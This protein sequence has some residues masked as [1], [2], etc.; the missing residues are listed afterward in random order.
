METSNTSEWSKKYEERAID[1]LAN[2]RYGA[3]AEDVLP[4]KQNTGNGTVGEI[5]VNDDFTMSETWT[6]K[7][8]TA[9]KFAVYGNVTGY[10]RELTVGAIYPEKA[11]GTTI[12]DYGFENIMYNAVRYAQYPIGLLITVGS[13]PFVDGDK[14]VF[15]TYAASYL[16]R[17]SGKLIMG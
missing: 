15:K 8:N 16:R 7:A 9:D 3:S 13:I 12:D 5:V 10:L 2:M 14:F 11:W 6:L 17:M 4:D 1:S